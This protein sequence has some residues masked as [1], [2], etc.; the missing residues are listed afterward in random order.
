M[1][2]HKGHVVYVLTYEDG[3]IIRYL[4]PA[5]DVQANDN[6]VGAMLR[7]DLQTGAIPEDMIKGWKRFA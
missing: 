1:S 2:C 6:V 3:R 4:V 5:A 7:T